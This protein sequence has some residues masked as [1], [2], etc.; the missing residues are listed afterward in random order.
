MSKNTKTNYAKPQVNKEASLIEK[1]DNYESFD[2]SKAE[3]VNVES[4]ETFEYVTVSN[5][6]KLNVR[7]AADKASEVLEI[8]DVEDILRVVEPSTNGWI[9]ALTI[10]GTTGY[11]MD[12][13]TKGA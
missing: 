12:E 10:K 5:C 3:T 8:V 6:K 4:E 9:K 11:V 7:K 1:P 13:F 2:D